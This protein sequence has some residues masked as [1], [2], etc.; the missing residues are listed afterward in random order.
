MESLS[1]GE[2]REEFIRRAHSVVWCSM[3]TVDAHGRPRSRVI[4]TIWESDGSTGYIGT[5][6]NSYKST[7]LVNNP[8]VSLA[9]ITDLVR[10]LYVEALA[11]WADDLE[12]R[13]RAWAMFK[14][15]A[16]PLGYD[17]SPIFI[18]PD[19]PRFGVLKLTPWRIQIETNPPHTKQIWRKQ[20]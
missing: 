20:D 10:P 7:H 19:H 4:H 9:Y 3:A 8:Y 16:P 13:L 5:Y 15:A 17:P 1:F 11:E 12:T 2:I 14:E 6:R 18:S